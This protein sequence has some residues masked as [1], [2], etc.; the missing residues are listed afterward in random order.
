[1]IG[2]KYFGFDRHVETRTRARTNSNA[3]QSR[4]ARWVPRVLANEPRSSPSGSAGGESRATLRG[5]PALRSRSLGG[6]RPCFR[7]PPAGRRR[8]GAR[9]DAGGNRSGRVA[10][11]SDRLRR[12]V[13][14]QRGRP[15]PAAVRHLDGDQGEFDRDRSLQRLRSREGGRERGARGFQRQVQRPG[16]RQGRDRTRLRRRPGQYRHHRDGR[17]H[18]LA[19]RREGGR[20]LR[21]F[22]RRELGLPRRAQRGRGRAPALSHL[23]RLQRRRNEE[24]LWLHRC[25]VRHRRAFEHGQGD[26]FR[27]QGAQGR[28]A[29]PVRSLSGPHR[30]RR[31]CPGRHTADDE[32]VPPVGRDT[33]RALRDRYQLRRE[34]HRPAAERDRGHQRHGVEPAG[35]G[36]ALH[37]HRHACRGHE[38][39]ADGEGAGRRGQRCGRQ[40][41]H[42]SGAAHRPDRHPKAAGADHQ[43]EPAR[44]G[45]GRV[46]RHHHLHRADQGVRADRS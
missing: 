45:H 34:R 37:R 4:A 17:A 12:P 43:G 18:L 22:L 31:A 35:R 25:G 15:I 33:E 42:R 39:L 32:T 11:H 30:G 9:T 26:R 5:H 10:A 3:A 14:A 27:Y 44:A 7:R 20:R 2:S 41:Q 24:G 23:D 6:G 46:R 28:I 36:R 8:T 40:R 21:R 13:P 29:R 1:M 38:R 16:F 19:E